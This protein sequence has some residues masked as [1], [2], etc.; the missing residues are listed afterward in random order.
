MTT[1]QAASVANPY[2]E[3]VM[4]PVQTELT[5][6]DLRVTGEIPDYL[7][8]RYLRNGPNPVAEVDPATYH[9]FTGDPMV[10]GVALRDGQARWYRNRW[11]RTPAVCAALGE[12]RP[13]RL[14]VRAGMQSVGPNTNVLGHAGKTLA[15]VE[16]G[17]ANYELT[18]ELDTVGTCDFDG[19]LAGGYTA[20]P[21]RDP[22]TGE[23]HA[24]SYSFARGKT[25]QYSVIDAGGRARRTVDIEVTGSPMMHDF[26]LTEKYV[27]V[28]DLPVTFD[29][30][31]VLP[32]SM[33][34]WLKAPARMV[35]SSLV[36]RVRMPSPI[37]AVVNRDTRPPGGLPYSW[38]ADY[39]ARIGV[40]PRE[41][42]AQGWVRAGEAQ[43]RWFDVE[44]CYVFHPLNAYTE[45]SPT[46]QELLVLDVVRYAKVFDVDRRGP[47]D[48]PPTLDRWT[49]NLDTGAVRTES[50]DDRPQEF[51]RINDS[52]LG[53]KHRFGYTVGINGGFIGD[54]Q[55]EM[56]TTLYKHDYLTGSSITAP[57]DPQLVLGEMSFVPRPGG[58]DEDDG[59]LMGMGHHRGDEEG[60]LVI[61]DAATCESVATVR[62]PQ[63][64]PMGFHGNWTPTD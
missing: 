23:L 34:R 47:G 26:S 40:M 58:R 3:G 6:T 1:S 53:T 46:G 38:N 61:L 29:S 24:V 21:H 63:R 48:A 55:A 37:T 56:S 14:N 45:V 32:V 31:Q 41:G 49:I 18:E 64:V 35:L 42:E 5:A 30:A 11:V 22:A 52:L 20:H 13:A 25:V 54:V 62:L 7:D 12:P 50:R 60:Q 8:G 27:V 43:V 2:L 15:L 57:I 59:I 44:P 19:T 39:P 51:P 10:H 36:G 16:G 4:G 28:Y 33:P 17:V 9:W